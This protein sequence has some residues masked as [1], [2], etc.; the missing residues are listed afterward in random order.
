MYT[1]EKEKK[2]HRNNMDMATHKRD[3]TD[4][5]P[6]TICARSLSLFDRAECG[7]KVTGL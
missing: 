3:E 7:F 5:I 2:S 6:S 4:R 1:G